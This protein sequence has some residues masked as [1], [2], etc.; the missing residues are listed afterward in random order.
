M[1]NV[2]QRYEILYHGTHLPYL[3]PHQRSSFDLHR[4]WLYQLYLLMVPLFQK[5]ISELM[6]QV[7]FLLL[8]ILHTYNSDISQVS[9]NLNAHVN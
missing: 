3:R 4:Y 8:S 9:Y 7:I 5:T 2:S 1:G 6:Q